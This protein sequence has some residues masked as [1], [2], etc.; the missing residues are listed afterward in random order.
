MLKKTL[1]SFHALMV[2][3][4]ILGCPPAVP[5]DPEPDTGNG[6]EGDVADGA[7]IAGS[8]LAT[9]TLECNE[10]DRPAAATKCKGIESAAE[11]GD[12]VDF[13]GDET[14]GVCAG[15]DMLKC[16][17][18]EW[19]CA[20]GN[21][22]EI[23]ADFE[24]KETLCDGLDNDCDGQVDVLDGVKVEEICPDIDA[25]DR[26]CDVCG[27]VFLHGVCD[28]NRDSVPISCVI[29]EG[30][31]GGE[32][33]YG[34]EY[35]CDLE[36][37]AEDHRYVA[38]EQLQLPWNP[39]AEE[40]DTDY[41]SYYC[42][43]KDNDCDGEVD[44]AMEYYPDDF[45]FEMLL[46]EDFTDCEAD[47]AVFL[48]E[49]AFSDIEHIEG[50]LKLDD[51]TGYL[52][53]KAKMAFR[54]V[55]DDVGFMCNKT[56]LATFEK[57][58]EASCDLLDNDC[59]GEVDEELSI[60]DSP[61]MNTG[62]CVDNDG[63]SLV[64]ATC[65]GEAEEPWKCYR[66]DE[67]LLN[68]DYQLVD[69]ELCAGML[70]E[71]PEG[72]AACEAEVLC[73][74]LD[75]DC[76]GET[77]E[78]LRYPQFE[79]DCENGAD[80]D[81]N[82]LTDCEEP[83]CG[84][85][86]PFCDDDNPPVPFW[87]PCKYEENDLPVHVGACAPDDNGET[88]VR[89]S[90]E[91]DGPGKADWLCD[92]TQLTEEKEGY[93]VK[94]KFDSSAETAQEMG[95]WC[96][97]E[98]NDCDGE[99]DNG[100]ET[101]QYFTATSCRFLGECAENLENAKCVAGNWDCTY[102]TGW[103]DSGAVEFKKGEELCGSD[104]LAAN[105]IWKEQF[106]DGLDN[107]CD[108]SVDE[109]L[110]GQGIE[111]D[112]A[113]GE[114]VGVGVC[115]EDLLDTRCELIDVVLGTYGFVCDMSQVADVYAEIEDEDRSL[116]DGMDNDCD[117]LIDEN[118]AAV[119]GDQMELY[120]V[121]CNHVG[122][123]AAGVQ[124]FCNKDEADPGVW[125]CD[126]GE[127]PYH[128]QEQGY[129]YDSGQ[130]GLVEVECDGVDNDCDG[131]TD[132]G[133]DQDLGDL[134]GALNPKLKSGCPLEGYCGSEM[135][136][137]CEVVDEIPSWVCDASTVPGWEDVEVS[138]DSVDNDC[139]GFTDMVGEFPLNDISEDGA[140]CK[141]L[142]V[143]GGAGVTAACVEGQYLCYYDGVLAYDG[144]KEATCDGMDN[145]CDGFT[146]E[147]LDWKETE[148]CNTKGAC[149][150]PA[151]TAQCFGAAGWDC[152]YELISDWEEIET[153]CDDID[154]DCDGTTDV[155]ACQ[156]CEPCQDDPDCMT[157]SCKLTPDQESYCAV[158]NFNCVMINYQTGLCQSVPDGTM[159]CQD[160]SNKC[161]CTGLGTW[162]CEGGGFHC[163]GATPVCHQ[164]ECKACKP[165]A[166]KCDGN[167]RVQCSPTGA[168][169]N[170]LSDCASG[171]ICLGQGQCV[172]NNEAV[173]AAG[174]SG[175]APD[176]SPAVAV[177]MS[178][179]PVVVWQSDN[180]A[181]GYLT[182]VALRR[183]SPEMMAEGSA[184]MVNSYTSKH[185]KNPAIASFSSNPGG[186]V[187]VWQ[188]ED[189]DGDNYG[190]FGQ[191]FNED[192]SKYGAELQIHTTAT[193]MQEFPKVATFG[194]GGFIV[195]WESNNGED[196]AGRGVYAQRFDGLG[197]AEGPEFLVNTTTT[198]DQR[199]PDVANLDDE[200]FVVTWTSVGQDES[201]QGVI[202]A[203]FDETG[204]QV[205][206]EYIASYYQ[207]SS[208]K[209]GV[210]GGFSGS[211][212]GQLMLA[213]ESYGQDPGGAN[214][215]FMLPYDEFG[216]KQEVQD[217]QVNTVVTNGNQKD[218]EV[219]IMADNS[220]VAVWETMYLDSDKDAVAG[221]LL[222]AD[223]SPVTE[224]E[225]L[226]NQTQE[227]SQQNPDVAVGQDQSYVV[228]WNSVPADNNPDI[229]IRMF[230][231]APSQ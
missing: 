91:P 34:K 22:E 205:S 7:D 189:Q 186:F 105:C 137:S 58:I 156:V 48:G 115:A 51:E 100:I 158:S 183:Y 217:V 93:V 129:S 43:N 14:K 207:A 54:C 194:T 134:A 77:D 120:A 146:D 33:V 187:V 67:L 135:K 63:V 155:A 193:G 5:S 149:A 106:C 160:E 8:E 175:S 25:E 95:R 71:D 159:A 219:A 139:D 80:D 157:N 83:N 97:G 61:C 99:V 102:G 9:D 79:E 27:G 210:A 96:D 68:P 214:G 153:S 188:S 39:D 166:M 163:A 17:G 12:E 89:V 38:I 118:I 103:L 215:V 141:T 116:C 109:E 171:F 184:I 226:V 92:Y 44:E 41:L 29:T 180:V 229:Y 133:L 201:G 36:A 142:G 218:P 16:E 23:S 111:K 50:A 2:C 192:G 147:D 18:G 104:K 20:I 144:P 206:Q 46:P 126:Y 143:C 124:A 202:F 24:Q 49:C 230:K 42:D 117:T 212:S 220:I 182:D 4:L 98:D 78:G 228:V 110:D 70:E 132:E 131:E 225:F 154:N 191:M 28:L 40:E 164:G 69:H 231:G 55:E 35:Q 101:F 177:R 123:C 85:L 81:D 174:V 148:A 107:D 90:C 113:C 10:E 145:D 21:L 47:G 122:A 211:L 32:P 152:F 31:E 200:G 19:I 6:V 216:L 170:P 84:A 73:D 221:K 127:V 59:D 224:D 26:V 130:G 199:W 213:W 168:A 128:S 195:T 162:Y 75:N 197:Q 179:G 56:Q 53:L 57:E 88:R 198:N 176:V 169:W 204:A 172:S 167:T 196:P 150:S 114:K 125:T 66:S 72:Y 138:C 112:L 13:T 45:D 65:V 223:G 222:N 37:L 3:M 227:G 161:L 108:G 136:W 74:G 62:V 203:L 30:D 86:H 76:D 173:V 1:V 165:N 94:E 52:D 11:A 121:P 178:G 140:N 181:G 64:E 208:Q 82:G 87:E 151:L 60:E 185:Q 119:G 209:R 190:I 15:V